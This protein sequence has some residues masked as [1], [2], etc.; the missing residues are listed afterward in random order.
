MYTPTSLSV[1]TR[2][3]VH[4]QQIQQVQ[5][6]RHRKTA[7]QLKEAQV[8]YMVKLGQWSHTTRPSTAQ[9][10]GP[11]G[12]TSPAACPTYPPLT[13]TPAH[14]HTWDFP[15]GSPVHI[16]QH[17]WKV[18]RP[19][20]GGSTRRQH[21]QLLLLH[22]HRSRNRLLPQT[23]RYT[24]NLLK[25]KCP[26]LTMLEREEARVHARTYSYIQTNSEK[27]TKT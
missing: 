24:R 4:K 15:G 22:P 13:V 3:P 6:E 19:S 2:G 20:G 18:G 1:H 17:L 5:E 25:L 8:I 26:V 7:G 27:H 23:G 21:H 12:P 16:C 11:R 14:T 9:A 10:R